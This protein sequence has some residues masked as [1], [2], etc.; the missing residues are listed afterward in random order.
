[1]STIVTKLEV[2]VVVFWLVSGPISM[3]QAQHHHHGGGGGYYGGGHHHHYGGGY[4]GGLSH[5]HHY[6]GGYYGGPYHH[7]HNSGIY[8]GGSGLGYGWSSGY[9]YGGYGGYG[10]SSGLRYSSGYRGGLYTLPPTISSG[11]YVTP[12]F[13]TPTPTYVG[14]RSA[15]S[16]T[17]QSPS[18]QPLTTAP[19][20]TDISTTRSELPG[21]TFGARAHLSELAVAVAD[22]ANLLCVSLHQEYSGNVHFKEVY[23]DTY[24]LITAA[25]QLAEK[26]ADPQTTMAI[27]SDMNA[28]VASVSPVI[29]SWRPS[30]GRPGSAVEHLSRVTSAVKLL[31][32]DAGW[33]G[34]KSASL[35]AGVPTPTAPPPE[36]IETPPPAAP[37][38]GQPGIGNEPTPIENAP[39]PAP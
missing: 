23:R 37:S 11:V 12:Q 19:G 38:P 25:K 8:I 28:I 18:V 22:R 21:V 26:H 17:Y 39:V 35:S 10:Y 3:A 7:H 13:I 34:S 30:A 27:V 9:P 24:M 5:H 31:S 2:L 32:V 33:D 4:S 14:Q 1:M 6:G 29:E 36:S 16:I 15:S 20:P